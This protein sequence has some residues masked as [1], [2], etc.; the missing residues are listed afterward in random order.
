MDSGKY[1]YQQEKK[2]KELKSK[3]GK[4]GEMKQIRLT[5]NISD[6]DMETRAIQAEKFLK[7]GDKVMIEMRLRGRENALKNF[8]REKTNKFLEILKK[9]IPFRIERGLKELPKR[10]T[11]IITKQ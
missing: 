3:M 9:R 7:K 6:H 1:L 5:F 2:E 4:A 8:A 10:L 11:L